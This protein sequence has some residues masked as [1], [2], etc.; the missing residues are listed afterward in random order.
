MTAT[1]WWAVLLDGSVGSIFGLVGLFLVFWLTLRHDRRREDSRRAEDALRVREERT[2]VAAHAVIQHFS[3]S[4]VGMSTEQ[5]SAWSDEAGSRLSLLQVLTKRDHPVVAR[6]ASDASMKLLS[7]L[8]A[9]EGQ[10]RARG[11]LLDDRIET[12]RVTESVSDVVRVLGEWM[13]GECD[14]AR[15]DAQARELREA[16]RGRGW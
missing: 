2:G 9:D 8:D 15:L 5:L 14:D 10:D 3:R 6:F 12:D 16:A 1:A 13:S 7:A 4:V 11:A